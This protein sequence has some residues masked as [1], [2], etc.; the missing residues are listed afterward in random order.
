M[1]SIGGASVR[2]GQLTSIFLAGCFLEKP[3]FLVEGRDSGLAMDFSGRAAGIPQPRSCR[4]RRGPAGLTIRS[5][6]SSWS[7]WRNDRL[8]S[9]RRGQP[10][11]ATGRLSRSVNGSMVLTLALRLRDD[12]GQSRPSP[13]PDDSTG[14]HRRKRL[15]WS[16]SVPDEIPASGGFDGRRTPARFEDPIEVLGSDRPIVVRANVRDEARRVPGLHFAE[17]TLVCRRP[18]LG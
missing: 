3:T 11:L 6:A 1:R 13:W 7:Q 15:R 9:P 17:V 16:A 8:R 4:R 18:C 10:A 5:P 14:P 12:R 2:S